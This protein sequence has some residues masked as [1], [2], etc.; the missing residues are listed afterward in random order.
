MTSTRT[1]L[2]LVAASLLL[3]AGAWMV[4]AWRRPP[5]RRTLLLTGFGPFGDY[6]T[7]PAWESVRVLDGVVLCD[8]VV[9][10]ARLDVVYREAPRQLAE[11][12]AAARP[13]AVLCLGVA[14]GEEILVETL[15]RNLDASPAP[16]NAGVVRRGP[17]RDGGPETIPTALPV[18]RILD[19]LAA[20]GYE[21]RPSEDAGSYLCNHLFYALMDSAGAG[22]PRGFVHVPSLGGRWDLERLR[23][24]VRLLVEAL[25]E[26]DDPPT[27]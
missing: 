26:G 21:A 27:S 5:P 6:A 20:A 7:N 10:T 15:A 4:D 13:D 14:P 2:L 18:A 12:M 17:I 24:A 9:R 23:A 19:R 22:G 3:A 8:M 1:G 25:A 11:A 16:D